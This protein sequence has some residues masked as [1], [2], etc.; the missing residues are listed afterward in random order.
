MRV[1]VHLPQFGRAAV[2]GGIEKAAKLAE[3]LG[4][5][6]VWVSD[7]LVAPAAQPYPAPYL[8][9]PLV[10]LAFAAAATTTVGI[11]TSVLVGPQYPSPLALANTLASLDNMSGGRLTVGI[12]IGWSKAEYEALHAPFDHRGARLEE[13]VDLLRTAWHD[14][15]ATHRGTY[16]PFED[17][18]VLPKPGHEVPIW[19]GGTSDAALER[20]CRKGD[21]FHGIG[22]A[23]EAAADLVR[24]LRAS[25]PEDSFT[26]S[27]R[28]PWDA[29]KVGADQLRAERDT[30]EAAG[31]QHVVAA[32][33]R[34]DLDTW[35]AGMETIART[36]DLQPR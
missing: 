32:P 16:Y 13:I 27:L 34:G 7:H 19:L 21:G 18:R 30:Y 28:V 8:Y 25:R 9:D 26:L 5:D 33:E 4:F 14:D 12:G 24:R 2:P 3:D 29:S 17:V 36:L 6:D 20:A 10:T 22:V 23:P 11:G 35:L 15:P 31:V 1:G